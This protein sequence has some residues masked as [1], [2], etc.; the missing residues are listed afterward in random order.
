MIDE[1]DG[2][3]STI[4]VAGNEKTVVFLFNQYVALGSFIRQL[5]VHFTT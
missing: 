4:G 3:N 5:M 1:L 2:F